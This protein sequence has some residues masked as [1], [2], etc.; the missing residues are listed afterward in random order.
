M[1]WWGKR[2]WAIGQTKNLSVGINVDNVW[3]NVDKWWAK[4]GRKSG[5]T[6]GQLGRSPPEALV[7]TLAVDSC[8]GRFRHWA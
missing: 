6:R 8:T 1:V 2:W 3:K 4:S 7:A 5:Q